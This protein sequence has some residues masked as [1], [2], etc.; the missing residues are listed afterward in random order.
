M[1]TENYYKG[2]KHILQLIPQN[3]ERCPQCN[4]M[5][6]K[7]DEAANHYLTKHDYKL[8]HVGTQSS[9]HGDG[10]IVHDITILLG[11]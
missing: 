4:E 6:N 2:I 5:L 3:I 10:D 1:T 9:F 7:L 11:K 8:L